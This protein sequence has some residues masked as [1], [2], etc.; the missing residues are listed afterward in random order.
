MANDGHVRIPNNI[1]DALITI[2]VPG[3]AMQ[4]LLFVIRKTIGW[5]KK[6]DK[7]SL[8]QIQTAT[9]LP[10][11][12]IIEARKK[13]VNMNIITITQKGNERTPNYGF[14]AHF[15]SWK[16]LPKKVIITQKGNPVTQKGKKPLPKRVHTTDSLKDTS[17][18]DNNPPIS[19]HKKIFILPD[20]IPKE[21]WEDYVAMR[22]QIR[23]PLT[24]GAVK[25]AVKELEKLKE[26]GDDPQ[27]VLE[28]S[29]LNSWQGLFELREKAKLTQQEKLD[30]ALME[31]E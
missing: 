29:T 16:P 2:R 8:S 10:K 4:V 12:K 25:L 5:N 28:Q 6:V 9:N 20:W 31:D 27:S 18:K 1:M 14:N 3:Q 7:I 11:H 23:K 24:T 19:P 15:K 13:L 21:T 30:K 17:S 22:K 26:Q